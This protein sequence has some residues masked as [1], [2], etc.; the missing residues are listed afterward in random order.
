MSTAARIDRIQP[1]PG[2]PRASLAPPWLRRTTLALSVGGLGVSPYLT[3]TSSVART[4]TPEPEPA[5][6]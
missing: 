6:R 3:I 5:A 1:G 4:A 2:R